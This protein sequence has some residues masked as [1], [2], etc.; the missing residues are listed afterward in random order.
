VIAGVI[1]C[2]A[3]A[4]P[5]AAAPPTAWAG[6]VRVPAG[7]EPVRIAVVLRGSA[8]DVTLGPGHP[9]RVRVVLRRDGV[10]LGFA[11]PGR[12]PLVFAGVVAGR[13]LAGTVRQGAARGSFALRPGVARD[14]AKTGL[15][16]R[17][18][19]S[20]L[21]VIA[22][23]YG[24]SLLDY[25]SGEIHGLFGASAAR[26]V[27]GAA[28]GRREPVAGEVRYP[29]AGALSWRGADAVRVGLRQLEVRFGSRGATLS[30]TLTLPPGGGPFPAAALVHGSGPDVRENSS[31][32]ATYLAS[33]GLATLVYDKR[34]V[35]WSGGTYP[36]GFAGDTTIDL[37]ARDAA[38]A[39]RF[40][41]T[42][43]EVDATRV[44]L[45]G[46]S[47]AGWIMPLAATRE[48]AI[49]WLVPLVG[50][51]VTQGESDAWGQGI[52]QG[53][54][55]TRTFAEVEAEVRAAGP[56]GVDPVPW[57]RRLRVPALWVWGGNDRHVPT[58][59]CVER[60]GPLVGEP[61][62]DL[63]YVVLPRANHGLLDSDTG[64]SAQVEASSTFAPELFARLDDWLRAR[65]LLA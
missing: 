15:Y 7:A 52:G 56:S 32:F 23:R 14:D 26:D 10:R 5:S 65:G 53:A 29:A 19:G 18:D 20:A 34:G 61:E 48:R 2:P 35:G 41:A 49:R 31:V 40:L 21:G 44:G 54:P 59:L 24:R 12:P 1:A 6:T 9:A 16:R 4:A 58:A 50:P 37:L 25:T 39:A 55:T 3:A 47:Q 11:L 36:G 27:V 64:L 43:P 38:A 51:T 57:I 8:A 22:T 45:V 30:G 60:L 13:K 17:P 62:R 46:Y 42:Q 28:V 63:S 33:R